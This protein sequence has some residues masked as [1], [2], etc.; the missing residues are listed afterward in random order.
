VKREEWRE[1]SSGRWACDF[2]GR[3]TWKGLTGRK[4]DGRL[5]KEKEPNT[6]KS[7][8]KDPLLQSIPCAMIHLHDSQD[9]FGQLSW[10]KGWM[11]GER[12]VAGEAPVIREG[13]GREITFPGNEFNQSMAWMS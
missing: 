5:T 1:I 2:V 13:N 12:T 9:H 10:N 7:G 4:S 8:G 3:L 11:G 6:K